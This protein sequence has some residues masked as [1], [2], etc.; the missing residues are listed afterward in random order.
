MMS[1]ERIFLQQILDLIAK[2][3]PLHHKSKNNIGEIVKQNGP[4][5]DVF[6]SLLYAFFKKQNYLQ[7]K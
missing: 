5:F 7:K 2:E 3:D 6:L 4:E 1:I